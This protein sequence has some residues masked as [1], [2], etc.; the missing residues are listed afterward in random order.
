MGKNLTGAVVASYDDK[1]S[2]G[3]EYVIGRL[4]GAV[5]TNLGVEQLDLIGG[6]THEAP[7]SLFIIDKSLGSG[8]SRC[9]INAGRP[10]RSNSHQ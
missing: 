1:A 3:I 6:T 2:V 8:L 10:H 7:T 4:S 5:G 9:K